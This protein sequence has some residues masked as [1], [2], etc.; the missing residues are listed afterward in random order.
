MEDVRQWLE[1]YKKQLILAGAAAMVLAPFLWPFFLAVLFQ[2]LCIA[3]PVIAAGTMIQ[4][5]REGKIHGQKRTEERF[6][7]KDSKI[8]AGAEVPGTG[9][10]G[11]P[12]VPQADPVQERDRKSGDQPL[13]ESEKNGRSRSDSS[14][15]AQMWYQME[16]R[17]RIFRLIRKL[18]KENIQSFSISPEGICSVREKNGYRRVGALRAFPY[19]ETH[20]LKKELGKD[21][22]QAAQKGRYLWLSWGKECG[23]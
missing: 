2:V 4:M 21:R 10:S 14:C 9:T 5:F 18:E 17:V 13:K 19:R 22:I 7:A 12:E 8:P 6:Y 16:G 23:R 3:I 20:T 15:M 11:S 1:S